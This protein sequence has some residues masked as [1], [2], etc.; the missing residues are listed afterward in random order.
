MQRLEKSRMPFSHVA[1]VKIYGFGAKAGSSA[2]VVLVELAEVTCGEA[3]RLFGAYHR[4]HR[5]TVPSSKCRPRSSAGRFDVTNDATR[6][7]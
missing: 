7:A 3:L 6:S 2:S 4:T 1:S 5:R